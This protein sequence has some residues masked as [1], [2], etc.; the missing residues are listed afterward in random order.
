MF[1]RRD[2]VR[3]YFTRRV[4]RR[5]R[6]RQRNVRWK[7]WT[8]SSCRSSDLSP[9]TPSLCPSFLASLRLKL[10][11]FQPRLPGYKM[12]PGAECFFSFF[13]VCVLQFARPPPCHCRALRFAA[14]FTITSGCDASQQQQSLL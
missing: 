11:V 7:R 6:S 2:A 12:S 1:A 13:C 10:A 8:D 4:R 3:G 14:V 5:C 9:D